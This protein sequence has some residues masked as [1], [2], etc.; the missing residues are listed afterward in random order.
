MKVM[1]AV[2]AAV[3]VLMLV[4]GTVNAQVKPASSAKQFKYK[5]AK[6]ETGMLYTYV[7]S[8]LAETKSG[9][10]LVFIPDKKRVEILRVT[11]GVEGGQLLTGEMNWDT[12]TLRQF[13]IWH[14]AKDGGKT[15]QATGAFSDEALSM[16]VEDPA[17]YRGAPGAKTFT[18]PL[19][20]LPAHIYSLDFVTLGLALRHFASS[21]G[22][23]D[24]DVL[25]ENMK[26]GPES[27]N[28][29]V[30]AGKVTVTFVEDVDRDGIPCS[31]YQLTGPALG[32]QQGFLW[33]H[34]DKGYLQDAE[35]P[36]PSSANW[37]DVK[38]TLRSA[39]KVSEGDWPIRRSLEIAGSSTAR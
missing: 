15:R 8:D 7:R 25:T 35:I 1:R 11:P 27:P 9:S 31:K 28:F 26:V 37:P 21:K 32:G 33:L 36:V 16:T 4:E 23:A 22:A 2:V 30:P 10:V 34:K 19:T 14:Q 3:G 6:I 24:V 13:E 39:E 18:V 38:L 12:F 5:G 29:I 20:Q 17:L